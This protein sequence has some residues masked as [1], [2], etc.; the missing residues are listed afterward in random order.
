MIA[1]PSDFVERRSN[2]LPEDL[3]QLEGELHGLTGL[4]NRE[5]LYQSAN[6]AIENYPGTIA[7]AIGDLDNLKFHN[8]TYGH[9]DGDEYIRTAA[10]VMSDT[11]RDSDV[12]GMV[13]HFGGDEF[14][15]IFTGMSTQTQVD[16]VINRMK[17]VLE[18]SY[19]IGISIGGRPHRPGESRRE[20]FEAVDKLMYADKIQRKISSYTPAQLEVVIA[21][22]KIAESAGIKPRDIELLSREVDI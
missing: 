5:S 14:A 17:G 21:L 3:P 4:P 2:Q 13:S 16:S 22:A 6:F 18:D 10:E 8:D 15:F 19:G 9:L 7:I 12:V 11:I 1:S 20:L